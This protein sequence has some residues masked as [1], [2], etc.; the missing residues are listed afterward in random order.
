M[1]LEMERHLNDLIIAVSNMEPDFRA[2]IEQK[3]FLDR[4]QRERKERMLQQKIEEQQKAMRRAHD[5]V[6]RRTGKPIMYRTNI[7]AGK[8]SENEESK[9]QQ[10]SSNDQYEQMMIKFFTP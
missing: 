1:L 3:I 9:N 5:D 7:A 10:H 8:K 2:R 6:P 4:R